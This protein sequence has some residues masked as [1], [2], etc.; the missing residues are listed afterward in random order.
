MLS[1]SPA[2]EKAQSLR[3]H[4]GLNDGYV[5][6]F[7]VL[8]RLG[9]EVYRAPVAGDAVEGTLIVRDGVAFM[10]VNSSGSLTRQR[11]TAA[12]ELGHYELG[13][14]HNGTE[15]V[16]DA[17][18]VADEREEEWDAFRFARHFLMDQSGVRRLVADINDEE[19]RVAAVASKFVVSP[20]V[21]A[22]HLAELALI[23]RSTKDRLRAAFDAGEI[24]PAAFLFR[25]GYAMDDMSSPVKSL[26]PGHIARALQAY[27]DGDLALVALAEVLQKDLDSARE[28]VAEA[29]LEVRDQ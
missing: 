15:I 23:K 10:F 5:D 11:L 29:G 3:Q 22:I 28:M 2:Q 19:E 18:A 13:G 14:R 12:H 24:K 27:A 9:I 21:A 16:E 7:D 20:K 6:V 26:D 25:Y 1:R 8:R 4:L 17:A